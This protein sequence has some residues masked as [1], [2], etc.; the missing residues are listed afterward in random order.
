MK[1]AEGCSTAFKR[2]S[3]IRGTGSGTDAALGSRMPNARYRSKLL[4]NAAL[5]AAR[6]GLTATV[7]LPSRLHARR[8]PAPPELQGA[9][10]T[11]PMHLRRHRL[12]LRKKPGQAVGP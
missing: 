4:A 11:A 7:D 2:E 10:I 5:G 12:G 3:G 1:A 6:R 8:H 9:E